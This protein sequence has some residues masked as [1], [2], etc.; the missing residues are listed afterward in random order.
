M[1]LAP[2]PGSGKRDQVGELVVPGVL[3][4]I[5][6]QHDALRLERLHRALIVG[7]QHNRAPVGAQGG[8][9]LAAARRV[10]VVRRLVKQQDVRAGDDE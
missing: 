6:Q 7:D 3:Y 10:E 1:G 5:G 2:K 9:D 8:Q 4:P